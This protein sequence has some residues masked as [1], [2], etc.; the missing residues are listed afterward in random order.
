MNPRTP[1]IIGAGQFTNRQAANAP[2]DHDA[3]LDPVH[4]MALALQAAEAA[5]G[6]KIASHL[7][8]VAVVPTVSW[9]YSDPAV[10]VARLLGAES[11]ETVLAPMG[12]HAPTVWPTRSRQGSSTLA[13]W[14]AGSPGEPETHTAS[15]A[16]RRRGGHN[17][18]TRHRRS[19][20]TQRRTSCSTR[21]NL[22]RG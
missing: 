6:V 14:S 3:E 21:P 1:V 13:A 17:R 5:S 12:G 2:T 11:A 7:Q 15:S 16:R 4:M 18:Q 22:R 10:A 9:R 8:S 20:G 19:D